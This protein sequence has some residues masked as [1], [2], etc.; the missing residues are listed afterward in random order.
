MAEFSAQ[1]RAI[2]KELDLLGIPNFVFEREGASDQ[3][4]EEMFL[5]AVRAASVY[6]GI[7][8]KIC[9]QYT[10][11][12]YELAREHKIACHLYVQHLDEA[13]RSE[14]LKEFLQSLKGVSDVKSIYYFQATDELVSQIKRDLWGWRDRLVGDEDGEKDKLDIKANLPILCDR[15]PQDFQFEEQVVSYFQN[16]SARP[17]ILL[18]PGPVN[19][20]HGYYLNRIKLFSLEKYLNK[21]GMRGGKKIVRI[22]QSPCLMTTP[23]H[24]RRA[25]LGELDAQETG[26]DEVIVD[27][28]K[29]TRLKA[30]LVVVRLMASE[31]E[32]N[33]QRS[34][35]LIAD[36]LADFP[37]TSKDV[38]VSVVVCLEEDRPSS[39]TQGRWNRIFGFIGFKKGDMDRF[40][41]SVKEIQQRY[42]DGSKL[43]VEMLPHLTS[44]KMGDV[45]RWLDHELVKPSVR[46]VLETEIEDIF[47]ER[48][49]L[50]MDDL[51]LRLT[52]LLEKRLG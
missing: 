19:E 51:Y 28:I 22:H 12:E 11:E 41:Q 42:Q 13:D 3:S 24:F 9:G 32:G 37:D 16:R 39:K 6:I 2:K 21:A 1:R 34:L 35:Q 33:P 45:R 10:R 25:I 26:D 48:D 38:L 44:P 31:C 23:I 17:L 14:E 43:R 49:S 18:L 30:F 20:K 5:S 36:Y 40:D 15:D 4:P 7:F 27:H 47:R 29:R 46:H 52:D 50:P 8:G